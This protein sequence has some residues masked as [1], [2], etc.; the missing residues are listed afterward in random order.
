MN[1]K[2]FLIAF[3]AAFVWIFLWGWL[4]NG[5]ILKSVYAETQGLWRPQAETM[6]LFHWMILGQAVLVF[7]FI[8][9]YAT[10]FSDGRHTG[11]HPAWNH[12]GDF[13]GRRSH[14]DICGAAYSR[15]TDRVLEYR[16][17]C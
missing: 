17:L 14:D 9:I 11:W 16:R 12:A 2:K 8:M 4:Y 6:S 13:G 7:A 10:G 1:A 3:V 5:V 15:Q